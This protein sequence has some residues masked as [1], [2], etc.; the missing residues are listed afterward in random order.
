MLY[1]EAAQFIDEEFFKG[2]HDKNSKTN[3]IALIHNRL[4]ADDAAK[5]PEYYGHREGVVHTSSI[6]KCLRGVVLG[7]LGAEADPVPEQ[8]RNRKL[9]VYKAGNLFEDFIVG[10]LGDKVLHAQREYQYKYKNL[11]VVGR[12]DF[13]FQD[14]EVVR[15]GESK[16]VNSDSFWHRQREGTL[17]AWNNQM[18]LEMYMWFE[19]ILAPFKCKHCGR[20]VLT[21][22]DAPLEV[23]CESVQGDSK[24]IFVPAPEEKLDNPQGYFTYVSKDDVTIIPAAIQFNQ[25]LIDTVA[26]PALDLINE[27]YTKKDA[28]LMPLPEMVVWNK[29]RQQWVT[30]W[31][32]TYCDH[33]CQ[34]AGK[35]WKLEAKQEVARKNLAEKA[36]TADMPHLKPKTK[37]TITVVNT[38]PLSADF[39]PEPGQT[40]IV[41]PEE[42][43]SITEFTPAVPVE[44]E[45]GA[46]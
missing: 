35:G 16:S 12:S 11:I 43:R 33:H 39:R 42:M 13:T 20:V 38:E 34:C 4:V 1:Q 25:K 37:P 29:S 46:N 17:I 14:G 36:K 6:T 45:S 2:T 7:M 27:G 10:T 3:L 21:N 5:D 23:T 28:S 26:I 44:V 9:G 19:R 24:C 31:L 32:C 18:Q 15:I 8:E 40:I 30:N 22:M 41:E